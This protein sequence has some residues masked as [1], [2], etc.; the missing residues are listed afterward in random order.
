MIGTLFAQEFRASWK[1]LFGSIGIALLVIALGF[2]VSLLKVPGLG[3]LG[4]GIAM[5]VAIVITPFV[6]GL[7]AEG[8]WRTM[9]GR[10]GYFT[11]T[12]P[13][14]GRTLFSSKVLYGILMAFV[15][16]A[17]MAVC[18]VVGVAVSAVSQGRSW[19]AGFG[20]VRDVLA[21]VEPSTMGFLIGAVLLQ[22]VFTVVAGAAVISI[23]AQGRFNHMGFGA[24]VLGAVFVYVAMQVLG[25]AA[26]LFV[27]FGLRISGPDAGSLVAEGMLDDFVTAVTSPGA[28]S[29][30]PNVIGLGIV[31][32]SIV[33]TAVLWW[34][35]VR[36][37]ERRTSLR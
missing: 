28:A 23:G 10:E 11:M 25:L 19:G 18:V 33:V 12:L 20:M 16:L 21:A 32:L 15:A 1:T 2:G 7:L 9:Y 35:G 30:E 8:Y 26:M 22:I 34:W 17:I 4:F 24:P 27:P 6:L 14:R 5:L 29:A 13:V 31:P 36:S 3:Q 37:V